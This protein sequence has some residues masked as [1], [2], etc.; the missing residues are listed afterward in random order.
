MTNAVF[1]G[2][3]ITAAALRIAGV[4]VQV[5]AMSDV[6]RTFEQAVDDAELVIITARYARAMDEASLRAAI[7]RADPLVL[8]M[9]DGGNRYPPEDLEPRIDRV[10][11][12]ER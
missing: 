7:R 11:G 1:I 12:I 10:L 6:P 3:E 4:T 5:P 8:V 2:D 9:P